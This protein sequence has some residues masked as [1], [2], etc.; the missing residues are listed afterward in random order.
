M[1]PCHDCFVDTLDTIGGLWSYHSGAAKAI[2]N[3]FAA[4]T[5]LHFCSGLCGGTGGGTVAAR[6]FGWALWCGTV[7]WSFA[8]H[9]VARS[10][11]VIYPMMTLLAIIVTAN[12]YWLD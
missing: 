11:S 6:H 9:P 5:S 1:F 3:P 12:H 2:A 10:L 7:W 8:R 4:M